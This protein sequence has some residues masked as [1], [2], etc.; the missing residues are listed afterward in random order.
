M[1][2]TCGDEQYMVSGYRPVLGHHRAALNDR[3]D[4]ALDSLA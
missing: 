4:I 3:Q 1:K 2:G